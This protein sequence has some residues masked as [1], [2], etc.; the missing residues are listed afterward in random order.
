MQ[1]FVSTDNHTEGSAKLNHYVKV[2]VDDTLRYFAD[3]ITRVEV[4]LRD[5]NSSQKSGDDDKRCVIEARLAG[6]RPIAVSH[7]GVTLEHA[8]N[9]AVD[10]LA[11]TLRRTLD[12]LDNPKG[13]STFAGNLPISTATSGV[14]W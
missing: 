10:K 9:G 3:R 4:H 13:R 8:L 14:G 2:V 11:K 12:R 1:I 7:H 6:L 5:E